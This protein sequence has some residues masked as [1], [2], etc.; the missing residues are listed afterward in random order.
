MEEIKSDSLDL[1]QDYKLTDKEE[2]FDPVKGEVV[3]KKDLLPWDIIKATALKLGYT[4]NNPKKSCKS[5]YGRGYIGLVT[6]TNQPIP[7]NCIYTYE[8]KKEIQVNPVWNRAVKRSKALRK[9]MKQ[10]V[11]N[12]RKLQELR[13]DNIQESTSGDNLIDTS[14]LTLD[15]LAIN[16]VKDNE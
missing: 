5:C 13:D 10:R 2:F 11:R 8:Q 3:D 4:V 16:E 6:G 9:E 12:L 14:A 15:T 1:G 7:C